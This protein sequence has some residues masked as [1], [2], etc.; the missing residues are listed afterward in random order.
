MEQQPE[1]QEIFEKA[2][3]RRQEKVNLLHR[4]TRE[5]YQNAAMKIEELNAWQPERKIEEIGNMNKWLK[6]Q[7]IN[8]EGYSDDDIVRAWA[9][10]GLRGKREAEEKQIDEK[11]K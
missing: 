7:G 6:E 9:L 11:Y 4:L 3:A 2:D 10:E 1:E 8:T 5:S